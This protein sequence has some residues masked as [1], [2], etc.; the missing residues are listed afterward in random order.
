MQKFIHP[1]IE[2]DMISPFFFGGMDES[3]VILAVCHVS[4]SR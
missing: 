1:S 3:K 4:S 2:K